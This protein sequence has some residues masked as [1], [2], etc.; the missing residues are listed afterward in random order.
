PAPDRRWSPAAGSAFARSL[1]VRA[2]WALARRGLGA[3]LESGL[4]ELE[5]PMTLDINHPTVPV[6]QRLVPETIVA[7]GSF[8]RALPHPN[9]L[10]AAARAAVFASAQEIASEQCIRSLLRSEHG[11]SSSGTQRI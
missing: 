3:P 1:T 6:L 9:S 11:S 5:P 2:A 7:G 4:V 10:S 8:A